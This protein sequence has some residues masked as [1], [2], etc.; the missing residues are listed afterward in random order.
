M[1]PAALPL[2]ALRLSQDAA[3]QWTTP[4]MWSEWK[5]GVKDTTVY[6]P[7]STS[8]HS[9]RHDTELR[10]GFY[11]PPIPLFFSPL[12]STYHF[13]ETAHTEYTHRSFFVKSSKHFNLIPPRPQRN[14]L[15]N[16]LN[17]STEIKNHRAYHLYWS[18]HK[19]KTGIEYMQFI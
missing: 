7:L 8:L 11:F 6:I 5:V 3:L 9:L 1:T 12:A 10:K 16:K 2:F 14:H 15:Y 18:H 4:N 13:T 17:W 19:T